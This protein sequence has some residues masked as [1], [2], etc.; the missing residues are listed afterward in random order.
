MTPAKTVERKPYYVEEL[1]A[2]G[3]LI[4]IISGIG[5]N[6]GTW[7]S[8]CYSLATARRWLREMRSD[9]PSRFFQIGTNM[10]GEVWTA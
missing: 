10:D 9:F 4:G 7:D 3:S 8:A 6:K 5:R 2:N 1:D